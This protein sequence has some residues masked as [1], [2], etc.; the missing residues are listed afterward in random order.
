MT[1]GF[2]AYESFPV[3]VHASPNATVTLKTIDTAPSPQQAAIGI[4]S[5]KLWSW[6]NP[7]NIQT[8]KNG[9]A[10][11][12]FT[13]VGAVMP[14]V[15]NDIANVSL[16]IVASSG[17]ATQGIAN[18]P[19]EFTGYSSGAIIQSA[20]PIFFE[21]TLVGQTGNLGIYRYVIVY[22][23]P[24]QNPS[25]P[26]HANMTV[27]GSWQ[28]GKVGPMPSGIDLSV[29]QSSFDLVPNQPFYFGISET[30]TLET[31]NNTR[32]Y[33]FSVQEQLGN[34]IYL[35]PLN[36]TITPS[37]PVDMSEPPLPLQTIQGVVAM[38]GL[39]WNSGNSGK[40]AL[41]GA[42]FTLGFVS[43]ILIIR[44]MRRGHE[45]DSTETVVRDPINE[46]TTR[47]DTGS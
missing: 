29:V 9:M 40:I 33:T 12:N 14:F 17:P 18:L 27:V 28:N 25:S 26:L 24:Q 15:A 11:S 45:V 5:N 39:I 32:N 4:N 34:S 2:V 31:S 37:F 6:F 35:E 1:V 16:P 10:N 42:A 20:S 30:N 41:L 7:T 21:R 19:I 46:R 22:N 44:R 8:D 47:Q 3:T 43:W 36:I 13:L 23:P 38:T